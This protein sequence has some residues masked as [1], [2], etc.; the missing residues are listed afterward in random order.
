[1]H[2]IKKIEKTKDK[3]RF[4]TNKKRIYWTDRK[5]IWRNRAARHAKKNYFFLL[6][7]I[8]LVRLY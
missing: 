6:L 2:L 1:M 4:K 3:K 7:G 8:K 5:E